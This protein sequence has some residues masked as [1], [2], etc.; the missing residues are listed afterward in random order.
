MTEMSSSP[1]GG[2]NFESLRHN[3]PA[4]RRRLG[5]CISLLALSVAA[6]S[7][8]PAIS[9]A[10]AASSFVQR[11]MMKRFDSNG[12]GAI[13]INE[14]ASLH[15]RIFSRLDSDRDG[16]ITEIEF[17]QGKKGNETRRAKGFA[18][19]DTDGS[20]TLSQAEFARLAP[21]MFARID[22]NDDGRLTPDE[23]QKARKN[24]KAMQ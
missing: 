19:L 6:H 1:H 20:R 9:S 18:R 17:V 16:L 15:A 3:H 22:G 23:M 10:E 5:L 24:M 14:F 7:T 21:A 13:T 4:L 8:A 11:M 2:A 12:D